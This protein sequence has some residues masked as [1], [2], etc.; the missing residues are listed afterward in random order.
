MNKSLVYLLLFHI[1][2]GLLFPSLTLLSNDLIQ[3]SNVTFN[4]E[5][6]HELEEKETEKK[7]FEE[8]IDVEY[9]K[10]NSCQILIHTLAKNYQSVFLSSFSPPPEVCWFNSLIKI[11][12]TSLHKRIKKIFNWKNISQILKETS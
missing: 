5:G 6:D 9:L 11:K 2:L 4:L 3:S 7:N 1:S 12:L 10:I 8:S